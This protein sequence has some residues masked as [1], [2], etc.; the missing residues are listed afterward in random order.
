MIFG[1]LGFF[2]LRFCHI[3]LEK[4][5]QNVILNLFQDLPRVKIKLS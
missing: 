2:G 3:E 5:N 4:I 1:L